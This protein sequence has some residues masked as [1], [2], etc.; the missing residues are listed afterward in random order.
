[1][2]SMSRFDMMAIL[3]AILEFRITHATLTLSV[4]VLMTKDS[5]L[6]NGSDLSSL[7]IVDCGSASFK[8]SVVELFRQ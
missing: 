1:M 2:V 5:K 3:T 7:E 8:K 6:I 4:V